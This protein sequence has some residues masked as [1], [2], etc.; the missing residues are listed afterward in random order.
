ALLAL[1]RGDDAQALKADQ[2]LTSALLADVEGDPRGA[3]EIVAVLRTDHRFPWPEELLVGAAASAHHRGDADTVRAAAGVLDALAERN[4]GV[5]SVIG[6]KLLVDALTT[7]DFEPALTRLR[8]TPRLLL[9]A[10]A[11]EEHG[12]AVVDGIDREAGLAALDAAHDQ[13]AELG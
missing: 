4:P 1:L 2:P 13:Y 3:A 7:K 9:A 5:G 6:A 11:D 10:R 12:R 8:A